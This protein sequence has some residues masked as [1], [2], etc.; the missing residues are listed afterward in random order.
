MGERGLK[1]EF[2]FNI[3]LL[4]ERVTKGEMAPL[5]YLTA[6]RNEI[7]RFNEG[8]DALK[9]NCMS[10]TF[11][12]K[13]ELREVNRKIHALFGDELPHYYGDRPK[14]MEMGIYLDTLKDLKEKAKENLFYRSRLLEFLETTQPITERD[15]A[16][17]QRLT[18]LLDRKLE[19]LIKIRLEV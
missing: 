18:E 11:L 7:V 17:D 10:D 1:E 5:E 12:A 15:Q 19:L 4:N 8:V 3:S 14:Q 9:T 13:R 16:F 2:L 6:H